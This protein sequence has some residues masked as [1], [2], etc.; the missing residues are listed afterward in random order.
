LAEKA[1][2][3]RGVM[4]DLCKH[5]GYERTYVNLEMLQNIMREDNVSVEQGDIVCLH[6]GLGDLI[7]N[8]PKSGPDPS[9][10]TACSV[11]DGA[12]PK[13]S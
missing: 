3:G 9:I 7:M 11:L 13:H 5:F 2:Q 4:I 8:S 6:T 10:K 12:D 1:V